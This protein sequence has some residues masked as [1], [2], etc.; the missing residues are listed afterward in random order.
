MATC[1]SCGAQIRWVKTKFGKTMPLD[2]KPT[3]DGN[4]ILED[5]VAVVIANTTTNLDRFTPHF[6]T[7]PHA[8]KHRKTKEKA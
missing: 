4:V 6:V 8:A 2:E 7:C 5:G 3:P 1:K